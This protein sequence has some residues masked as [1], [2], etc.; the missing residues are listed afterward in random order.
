MGYA[1]VPVETCYGIF[2]IGEGIDLG[3]REKPEDCTN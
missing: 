3:F 2:E 1:M